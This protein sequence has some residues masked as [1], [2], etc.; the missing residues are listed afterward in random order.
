MDKL[1]CMSF[2]DW[3]KAY[4]ALV[5]EYEDVETLCEDCDGTGK[6]T[7]DECDTEKDCETCEGTGKL[8]SEDNKNL[9]P[10]Y[11]EIVR[12]DRINLNT[13]R[14]LM[15]KKLNHLGCPFS[16]VGNKKF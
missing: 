8:S 6:I 5:E 1:Y 4:P 16:F 12:N 10:L 11:D 13:Y 7:C 9:R 15:T 3:L 2:K 14:K